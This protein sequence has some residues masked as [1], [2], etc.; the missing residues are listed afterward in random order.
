M[1]TS[2]TIYTTNVCPFAQSVL[3]LANLKKLAYKIVEIDLDNKPAYFLK[4]TPYGKVPLIEHDNKVVYETSIIL[5]Y[6]EEVFPG[7]AFL[8]KDAHT[9][10]MQRIWIKYCGSDFIPIYYKV[11][12]NQD[13]DKRNSY[14][15]MLIDTVKF[16]EA[17]FEKHANGGAY[18]FGDQITLVDICFYPFFERFVV[19]AFYRDA[20]IPKD[21]VRIRNWLRLMRENPAIKTTSN[22]PDF[23][24]KRYSKY[25]DGTT[26]RSGASKIIDDL[27]G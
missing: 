20:D 17:G 10:A 16:I 13:I 2:L 25:A 9:K 26:N 6:L 8:S 23:Y 22:S 1:T 21:C 7:Q 11:L 18:F 19:N 12:L 3:I 4:L 27:W 15:S 14:K 5:E 24:I